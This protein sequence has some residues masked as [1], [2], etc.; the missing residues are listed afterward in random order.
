MDSP[1]SCQVDA[2]GADPEVLQPW[3]SEKLSQKNREPNTD[4]DDAPRSARERLRAAVQTL[5]VRAGRPAANDGAVASR[6][7]LSTSAVA[8]ILAAPSCPTRPSSRPSY[9]S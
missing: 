7:L 3:E 1:A 9:A 8:S 2:G 5:H 4:L 6:W